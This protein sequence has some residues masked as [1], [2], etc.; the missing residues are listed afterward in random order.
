MSYEVQMASL[1]E[2]LYKKNHHYIVP[3]KPKK[4]SAYKLTML[5]KVISQVTNQ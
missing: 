2:W 5:W 4:S 3:C 1:E